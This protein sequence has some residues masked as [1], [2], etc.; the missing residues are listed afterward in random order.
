MT[1]PMIVTLPF[2]L[3]LIDYWPLRRN[4]LLLRE[5]VPL[6]ALSAA[7]AVTTF[8]IQRA[9]GAVRHAASFPLELRIENALL[10][11]AMY[12]ATTFWPA[13]LTVFYPFPAEVPAWEWISAAI[14][15]LAVS[16]AAWRL[17]GAYP[18]FM[19][20]WFW[21]LG[22]LVPVIG[23]VQVGSQ[24]RADRYMYVPLVGVTIVIAWGAQ[25]IWTRRPSVR[26]VLIA[27][28]AAVLIACIIETS[29]QL[30]TWVNSETL[31]RHAIAVTN[32][33]YLAL[34]NLGSALLDEPGR[35]PEAVALLNESLRIKPDSASVHT[36]L[37]TAF[38]KMGRFP[39]AITEY[40]AALT[41][42]PES[43][44][45]RKNL[46]A[47]RA[48]A[49]IAEN[50]TGAELSHD[51]SRL[52][53]S[54]AHYKT[55]L[56][57]DPDSAETHYNLAVVLAKM[58]GRSQDAIRQFEEALRLRPD[59]AEAQNDL[60]VVLARTNPKE[61][62]P[63]FEAAVRIKPDYAEAHYNLAV[64]LSQ[65]PGRMPDAISHFEAAERIQPDPQIERILT[66]LRKR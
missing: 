7:A 2:V 65:L 29:I 12:I 55:A 16:M 1:K 27:G 64:A 35:L 38:S 21:F 22:V 5:K 23:L 4:A 18:F 47:V 46:R 11:Y 32:R 10:S 53:A 20:G 58:D 51:P 43:E 37:G 34:H 8:Y 48:N 25:A 42:A 52:D 6:F 45:A 49:A 36:D 44:I 15:L 62:V 57:F 9:S 31:F 13:R 60:G 17:R 41:I 14:A 3:L 24:A 54:V 61:A 66:R 28:A 40:E 19:V 59:Y 33:N 56:Q 50:N 39:E 26:P 30:Q 63:H